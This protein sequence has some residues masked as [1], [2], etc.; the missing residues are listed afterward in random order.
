LKRS[1]NAPTDA[2]AQLRRLLALIPRV[3]DGDEHPIAEM[4]EL[5]GVDAKTVVDDL[6]SIGGR[7]DT[8]GGFVEGLE[9]YIDAENASVKT[10]H[11]LR[12]MRLT[13]AELRALDLGLGM[14]RVERAPGEWATIDKARERIRR[15]AARLPA[16]GARDDPLA[17]A[18]S[19]GGGSSL[20]TVREALKTRRKLR[21]VYRRGN[22]V[23]A[24]A[25]IVC[26]YRLILA[27]PVWYLVGHCEK[28]EAMRIFRV[29]RIEEATALHET[30][31]IPDLASID[32]Q[33]AKGPVFVSEAPV[34]LR[35]RY[36]PRI[37]RWL[38]EHET[39][40]KDPDG[41]F[42]VEYPLADL[43]WA[44][45]HVLQYGP[46][47]EILEP[48]EARKAIANRLRGIAAG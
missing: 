11:F 37:A 20:G 1:K 13:I 46:E 36:S 35:V 38:E 2:S 29:D 24:T 28:S 27:G 22:A 32:E 44:M 18:S 25:R 33:L 10:D 19:G 5:L 43:E 31:A 30:C 39:G 48:P 4:A 3:A 15:V 45:R 23:E 17:I 41:S 6:T 7:F 47:A 16:N 21:I 42:I 12:P 9:I 40:R 34:R 14:I 8:P 26:P